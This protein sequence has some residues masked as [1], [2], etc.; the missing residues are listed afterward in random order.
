MDHLPIESIPALYDAWRVRQLARDERHDIIDSV[1]AGEFQIFD[2]DEERLTSS[3]PN[4]IQVALED[5]AEAASLLPTV[6]V[7]PTKKG[8]EAKKAAMKTERVCAGYMETNEID[9]FIPRSIMDAGAYGFHATTILPDFEENRPLIE[10]RD[11]RT[12]Y[13]EE[14]YNPGDTVRKALI[15]RAIHYSELP[16]A[17]RVKIKRTLSEGVLFEGNLHVVDEINENDKVVIVEY[18]D[19]EEMLIAAIYDASSSVSIGKAEAVKLPIE[20]RRMENKTGLCPMV[21]GPRVSLDGEFR[22][23]FDQ[24]VGM[25]EAHIRLFALVMDYADQAVYSDIFVKDLI[26]EMPYGGGAFIE[27]GPN[28]QIGRVPPAV[29][30]LDVQR[31]LEHLA[32]GIHLGARWPK[33]RPGEIDQSI[34]SAKFLE[35]SVGMLNT[36][37]RTY[38]QLLQRS[39]AKAMR[40]ALATDKAWFPGT[41]T[42]RGVLRNQEFLEEYNPSTDIDLEAKVRVD[43]GLG[44]GRDP[45]QSAVLHIQYSGSGLISEETVRENIDGIRDINLELS[46]IDTEQMRKMML[47]KLL[48]GLETG[49]VPNS[50]LVEMYRARE[51]GEPIVDIYEEFV[52]EPEE[53]AR[54]QSLPT[55]LTGGGVLGGGPPPTGPAPAGPGVP[56]APG[57]TDLMARLNVPA[58]PGGT[59]GTQVLQEA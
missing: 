19:T 6:R 25:L 53:E 26:G 49:E 38:H 58:G 15:A 7:Q 27:L 48:Q 42:A 32:D 51:K 16:E 4:M 3:S 13:V 20:L 21:I 44:F 23:Q 34:A 59:L 35:S 39:L 47:A 55:G 22:G 46:R 31:D 18:Y 5:T 24:V 30:S 14:G 36:A 37:I 56:P 9:L 11:P 28:G 43:Y 45:G 33:S 50:A 41:K 8:P 10:R 29:S 54:E 1:V 52:V 17:W 2:P 12:V 57:G 40:I